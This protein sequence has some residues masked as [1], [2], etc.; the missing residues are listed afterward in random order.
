M[1]LGAGRAGYLAVTA[2][3]GEDKVTAI[4]EQQ[5]SQHTWSADRVIGFYVEGVDGFAGLI[6]DA[7]LEVGSGYVVVDAGRWIDGPK[8]LL[9]VGLVSLVDVGL[10]TVYVNAT[11]QQI[12]DGLE[13]NEDYAGDA[14]RGDPGPYL[15]VGEAASGVTR[16]GSV[17]A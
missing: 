8:I 7:T 5:F 17:A 11:K 3:N 4:D 1:R 14:Y 6:D 13:Y 10:G 2:R 9:P 12:R 15:E 16:P